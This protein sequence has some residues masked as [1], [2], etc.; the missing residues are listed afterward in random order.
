[1][2][3]ELILYRGMGQETC[4]EVLGFFARVGREMNGQVFGFVEERV[5]SLEK[6]YAYYNL[7]DTL[8]R[9]SKPQAQILS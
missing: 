5:E 7:L 6:G 9:G 1:V 8:V 4:L 3:D 2:I